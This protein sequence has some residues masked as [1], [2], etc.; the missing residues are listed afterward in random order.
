RPVSVFA[1]PFRVAGMPA[2]DG[3]SGL[4]SDAAP[5]TRNVTNTDDGDID[6]LARQ[7]I[8]DVE[9]FWSST[10]PSTFPGKFR[11]VRDLLSWDARDFAN[12]GFCGDITFTFVNAGYCHD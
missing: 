9:Q 2:T 5:P 7:A 1:D 3:P 12:V 11:P 4:R 8:S 10:Y 6:E